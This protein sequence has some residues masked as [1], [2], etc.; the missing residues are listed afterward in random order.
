MFNVIGYIFDFKYISVFAAVSQVNKFE[1]RSRLLTDAMNY[2]GVCT[3]EQAAEVWARGLKE[4]SAAL[5]YA[6]MNESIKSQYAQQLEKNAPNWVTG[7]SS[8]WV[9]NFRIVRSESKSE[10][11]QV[12]EILFNTATS[13]GPANSYKA[14]L[15]I[16]LEGTFWRI[17][18]IEMDEELYIYTGFTP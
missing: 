12:I 9:D 10:H 5:Q 6:V 2:V 13:T 3:P 18:Q 17:C 1:I 4:R 15:N 11:E 16:C 14:M 8:P 7:V